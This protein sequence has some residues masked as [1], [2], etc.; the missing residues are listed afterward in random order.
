LAFAPA[1]PELVSALKPSS[2]TGTL[3]PAPLRWQIGRTDESSY[4]SLFRGNLPRF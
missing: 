4:F 3:R 1:L 2:G